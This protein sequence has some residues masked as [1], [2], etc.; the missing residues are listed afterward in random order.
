MTPSPN[1]Q[2]SNRIY[3]I[4][5]VKNYTDISDPRNLP[6]GVII[7]AKVNGNSLE[8]DGWGIFYRQ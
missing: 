5:L 6:K 4:I 8:L 2:R 3:A 1:E 7:K